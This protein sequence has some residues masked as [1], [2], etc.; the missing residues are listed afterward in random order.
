[1]FGLGKDQQQI[2]ELAEIA[3]ELVANLYIN[4]PENETF[5]QSGIINCLEAIKEFI[6]EDEIGLAIEHLLYLIYES[7]I[8]YPESELHK[9]HALASKYE[10]N[11]FYAT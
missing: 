6:N 10:I 7:D 4:E 5:E 9:V 11:N 8:F 1:M 2:I 3:Q